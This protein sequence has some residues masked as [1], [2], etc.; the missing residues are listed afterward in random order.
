M[1]I[2]ID[3]LLKEMSSAKGSDLHLRSHSFPVVRLDGRLTPLEK[4][5]E[6][7]LNDLEEMCRAMMNEHQEKTFRERFECDFSYSL[8]GTGRFRGNAFRQRG[9]INVVLRIVPT[10]IPTFE[11]VGLPLVLKKLADQSR[12]L[13]LVTGTTG[14]GKSTTLAA[15]VNH[16]NETR[17]CHVVT[18]ED[19]IEFLH[20]DQK[21]IISQREI[22]QDTLSYAE[23]LRHLVR[24][25]PDVVLIGEMRDPETMAAALT[26]AQTGH[27]VLATIHTID[28]VQTVTRIVDLFPPHQ[29]IQV[30]L[31][32]ADT[33]RG[34]VSQRLLARADGPGRVPAVE[35]L[36]V[37]GLVRKMIEENRLSDI[38]EQMQKGGYYGMQ[39]FN[40][41]LVTLC[42]KKM[43][44]LEEALS[45]A[46][47]P[48][49][50]MMALRGIE[51]QSG[52][53]T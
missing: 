2:K 39:T 13:I 44:V 14:S 33:L 15:M 17:T 8:S 40:Q 26:A 31:Q 18:I 45:A 28:A 49:E 21:S 34:V 41:S 20:R 53:T 47:N 36:V 23:A 11:E 3:D 5:G 29:Q 46:A 38:S 48:E 4:Y 25:D 43:V 32:L 1:A 37:T 30:R 10:K 9:G 52:A 27:L 16:I 22:G 42:N 51:S 35:V 12:G 7:T 19:P 6:L 50:L 24:Q